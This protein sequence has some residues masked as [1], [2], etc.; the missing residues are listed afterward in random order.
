[1]KIAD[2]FQVVLTWEDF[3][4]WLS[5]ACH[6]SH[7][8]IHA[9][10]GIPAIL[11]F[12]RLMRKPLASL[13]P[14]GLIALLEL[15]NEVLDF[16][17][18]F[19]PGWVWNYQATAIEVVLTLAP[20]AGLIFVARAWEKSRAAIRSNNGAPASIEPRT[21]LLP[22]SGGSRQL[23]N[24]LGLSASPKG[25]GLPEIFRAR[26]LSGP[27]SLE[28]WHEPDRPSR[29]AVGGQAAGRKDI[30]GDLPLGRPRT[31]HGRR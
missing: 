4:D 7:W 5:G 6:V 3:K 16:L 23:R 22:K 24:S 9:A 19:V 18:D 27:T 29:Y 17:R 21:S 13:V 28:S 30:R 14:L 10:I 26:G 25:L 15:I 2:L 8:T 11:I 20:P 1:M 31:P 12:G